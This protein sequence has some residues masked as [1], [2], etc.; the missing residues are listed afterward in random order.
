MRC[1]IYEEKGRTGKAALNSDAQGISQ[2]S[3]GW[4]HVPRR[5]T[6]VRGPQTAIPMASSL[7]GLVASS[8][9]IPCG[10]LAG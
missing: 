5:P 7:G 10:I 4:P 8:A 3:R 1:H 6:H 2:A 9:A